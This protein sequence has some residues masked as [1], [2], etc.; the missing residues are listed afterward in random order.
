MNNKTL[1]HNGVKVKIIDNQNLLTDN[2]IEKL[3]QYFDS[4]KAIIYFND[5]TSKHWLFDFEIDNVWFS[6]K[7]I[8][9]ELTRITIEC[10]K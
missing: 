6:S 2:I 5:C 4:G 1:N 8:N 9:N 7:S 10:F 3:K